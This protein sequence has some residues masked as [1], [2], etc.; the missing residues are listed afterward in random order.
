MSHYY[1]AKTPNGELVGLFRLRDVG[2]CHEIDPH[3]FATPAVG[4][5]KDLVK[6]G[7]AEWTTV[8]ALL[9]LHPENAPKS[10]PAIPPP[11]P[12]F[13]TD[14]SDPLSPP[15]SSTKPS[16]CL[17]LAGN[18]IVVL[19]FFLFT[20]LVATIADF[21]LA[22]HGPNASIFGFNLIILAAA[23]ALKVVGQRIVALC[24]FLGLVASVFLYGLAMLWGLAWGAFR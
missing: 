21:S 13:G 14:G 5:Y 22:S 2:S 9:A 19:F 15:S 4:S 8:A 23:I 24:M 20:F 6:K 12:D 10:P 18:A 3:H 7:A 1:V 17:Y 16:G 11:L